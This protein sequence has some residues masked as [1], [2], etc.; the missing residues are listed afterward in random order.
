M[1]ACLLIDKKVDV[2]FMWRCI[3]ILFNP[4]KKA[5]EIRGCDRRRWEK[6]EL[7]VGITLIEVT[8]VNNKSYIYLVLT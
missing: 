8:L 3:R 5:L 1:I 2:Y 7:A 6:R 4:L